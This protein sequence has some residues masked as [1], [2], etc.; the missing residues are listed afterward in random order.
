MKTII[1]KMVL[2]ASLLLIT[3][4]SSKPAQPKPLGYYT[5]EEF[6]KDE[7][8]ILSYIDYVKK[9]NLKPKVNSS[10]P[11]SVSEDYLNGIKEQLSYKINL[12]SRTIYADFKYRNGTLKDYLDQYPF[13]S[14]YDSEAFVENTNTKVSFTR[15]S[16]VTLKNLDTANVINIDRIYSTFLT[17]PLIFKNKD[18]LVEAGFV[19]SLAKYSTRG[20]FYITITNLTNKFIDISTISVYV[21]SEI[22]SMQLPIKLPPKG[23]IKNRVLQVSNYDMYK[24]VNSLNDTRVFAGAV[25]YSIDQKNESLFEEK[26]LKFK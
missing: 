20:Q 1:F 14:S 4:C 7:P 3:G 26:V 12:N 15:P 2:V 18:L 21:D 13:T 23:T 10:L 22:N 25:E 9:L 5:E 19:H 24:Q 16:I 6:K 8:Q 11:F 17:E